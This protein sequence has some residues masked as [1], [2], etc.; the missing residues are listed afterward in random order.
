MRRVVITGIGAVCAGAHNKEELEEICAE[1][2]VGIKKCSAFDTAG[3]STD[4]FGEAELS[5]DNRCYELIEKAGSQMLDD[6]G[7]SSSYISSLGRRCRLFFGTLMADSDSYTKHSKAKAEGRAENCLCDMNGYAYYAAGLFGVRGSVNVC[8]VACASGTSAAGM[9]LRYISS[10]RCDA[11]VVGGADPLTPL[12]AYG[13][14]VLR[15]MSS[16]ICSPFDENR[17]GISIGECGAFFFVEELE[18]ARARG[19]H[20]YCELAG[21][22][23]GNDAYHIT[24]PEPSGKEAE[25]TIR[26]ALE[27]AGITADK[28]DYING[29]GTGTQ[30]NDLMEKKACDL[31]FA[32]LPKRPYMSSTKALTGHCMGSSGAIELAS[33]IMSMQS[34]RPIVMPAL[35]EPIEDSEMFR[36]PARIDISFAMSNSFAFGGSS[37]SLIVKRYTEEQ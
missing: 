11:A 9:A 3:L 23:S 35:K 5:S 21:F 12:S 7:I 13:F 36:A 22:A 24:S 28:L 10:G 1:G 4:M 29:H 27:S 14:N 37:A 15:A 16:G 25:A 34:G 17:D 31:V 32:E 8:S 33:V 6:A 26:R 30:L 19:A 20:I 18:H 2:K